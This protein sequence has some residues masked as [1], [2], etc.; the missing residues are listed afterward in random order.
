M[1]DPSEVEKLHRIIFELR[2]RQEHLT[3]GLHGAS[4]VMAGIA[5]QLELKLD[6]AKMA[7]DLRE[8][9]ADIKGIIDAIKE[10]KVTT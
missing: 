10:G 2:E 1:T 5:G 9:T 8:S 3:Q 4:M 6:I 7:K